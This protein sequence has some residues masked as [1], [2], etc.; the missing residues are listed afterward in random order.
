MP[1]TFIL[2]RKLFP[3]TIALVLLWACA[4]VVFLL[5]HPLSGQVASAFPVQPAYAGRAGVNLEAS[6]LT[7]DRLAR[8][9]AELDAAGIRWVRFTLPWDQIEPARD[10][11]DWAQPDAIFAELAKHPAIEAVAVLN[12]SP[13][14]ARGAADADNP[15]APPHERADFGAFAATVARRYGDRLRYYQVWHE[16]NIAP[17]W[18]A[19]P[20]DPAGYLG[21]LR[22]AA[23][24]IRAADAD[25]RIVLAALAPTTEAGGRNLS[26]I[27]YLDA[28]YGLGARAW[29]DIA[30]A[31]PYGFSQPPDAAAD[32]SALNFERVTLLRQVMVAHGDAITPLWATAFGWNASPAGESPW[33]NVSEADQ[34]RYA[35]QALGMARGE[36]PWLGP[37]FWAAYCPDRPAGDLWLGFATCGTDAPR[38]VWAALTAAAADVLSPGRHSADDPALHYGSGWRVTPSAA[39]PSKDGDGLDFAFDGTG[40]ALRIQGGPYWA[41]YRITVDGAPANALPR[42]ETGAAYLVLHDPLA[43]TRWVAVARNLPAGTHNVRLVAIGGWGQWA[44]QGLAV[45]TG[46]DRPVWAAWALLVLAL[47]ATAGWTLLAWLACRRVAAWT[48]ARLDAAA[49]W[50]DALFWTAA[51]GCALLLVLSHRAAFDLA[52]LLGLGLLFLVRPDVSLPLIAASL[53]FWQQPEHLLRW[54]LAHFEIFLWLAVLA[55]AA[56]LIVAHLADPEAGSWKLEVG[57]WRL[58]AGSWRLEAGSWRP[59]VG[60]W[61]LE[62]GTHSPQPG[63]WNLEPVTRNAQP[64]TRNLEPGTLNLEPGTRNP[65]PA[66]RNLDWP[67]LALFLSGL[68][69]TIAAQEQ[70]V[71]WREFRMVFLGGALFYWL[72][73]RTPWPQGRRFSPWPLLNG[74]LAGMVAVSL[75]G[76]WQLVTGQGRVDVEGVWRV[77]ALYGSPNN[78]ALVLDRAA[79]L[80]LALAAFGAWGTAGGQ[81]RRAGQRGPGRFAIAPTTVSLISRWSY[82]LVA[83]I[84]TLAC[85]FTFSKGG[86]LLGLPAGLGLVLIGGAWRSGR[87]WPLWALGGLAVVAAIGLLLLFR[88][89]RFADLFNFGAGTTFVRIKLWRGALQMALAHPLLGVGPDNF[90]Y[91]YRTRYVL[92]SAWQELNLSHPHNIFLDLWT[93]LGLIGVLAGGWALIAGWARG[94]R[95]F[96]TGAADVWPLALG[97]LGALAATVTHGLIDNS[98]FL[99]DLMGIFMITLGVFQRTR[100]YSTFR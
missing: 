13:A 59:E 30:A 39:D 7:G 69:S 55:L 33:G 65:E 85:V 9:L 3:I 98:L 37:L 53:P 41:F 61:R 1:L 86:L 52:A 32:P 12:G 62:A 79:P 20:A 71:A 45:T 27:S 75:I 54:D 80:A 49:A 42:D 25:A 2:K 56:R 81:A 38:P 74:L 10:Q 36:W 72:I 34:A 84:V 89:P 99:V 21:L 66:T 48:R 16:P 94:W 77:R 57:S 26:D 31:Q 35:A 70:G 96:R 17:Y 40:L 83:V 73:T 51:A 28:L 23:V 29:F 91:A 88:T 44:L 93:R 46:T 15:Q 60:G 47:L 63:T 95:L 18:G 11:F 87:R 19:G 6:E 14:W 4:I 92:P 100:Y 67:V 58:E 97:L 5:V 90:L 50:P 43:A 76:L 24:Q 64:G 22:E 82:L 78:L 68:I 8:T